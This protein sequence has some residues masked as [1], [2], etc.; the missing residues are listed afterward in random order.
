MST[1]RCA[2]LVLSVI[3]LTACAGVSHKPLIPV[4]PETISPAWQRIG[5]ET[6]PPAQAPEAA[7]ALKPSQWVR[8]SYRRNGST[9]AVDAFGLSTAASAFEAQQ[10]WRNQPGVVA[11]HKGRVFVVCSS[12]SEP[13][14]GLIEFSRQL[15]TAWLRGLGD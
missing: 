4:P 3:A 2:C 13:V 15:E 8:T 9:V 14:Q 10:K 7:L 5:L 6:P 11:F 1:G 12:E